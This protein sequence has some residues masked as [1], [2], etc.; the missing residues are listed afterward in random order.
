[1][2]E[3]D[4][5]SGPAELLEAVRKPLGYHLGGEHHLRLGGGT[6]LAARWAHRHSTDV[7]LYV[8]HRIH[9][10]LFVSGLPADLHQLTNGRALVTSAPDLTRIDLPDGEITV[11]SAHS[12]TERP[13]SRDTV[14]GTAIG[15]D[16]NAE[17][18]AR[19]L[20]YRMLG[21]PGFIAGDLYDLAVARRHDAEGLATAL[22]T[23]PRDNIVSLQ[24][25]LRA[26]DQ[27]HLNTS[28]RP[29]LRPTH[30]HEAA[31]SVTILHRELDRYLADRPPPAHDRDIPPTRDR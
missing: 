26:I 20:A 22:D 9:Q 10:R 3:Y 2:A 27:D 21:S 4:L 16:T 15:M 30:P 18:L 1:M 28:T 19:K 5:P 14:R 25:V 7:D 12:R 24:R 17:I 8:D 11:D 31:H 23:L 29:L 6:A 13:R